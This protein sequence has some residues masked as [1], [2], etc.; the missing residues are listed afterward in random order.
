MIILRGSR[1]SGGFAIGRQEK[2]SAAQVSFQSRY[3][4][5]ARMDEQGQVVLPPETGV[6]PGERLLA[7]RGSGLALGFL[8]R[9]PIYAEALKHPEI[10]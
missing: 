5:N 2:L 6:Q 3:L 8:Q 1:R 7:V 4:G 9:G 10:P